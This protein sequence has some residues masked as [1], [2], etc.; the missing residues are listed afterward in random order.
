MF[1]G[2]NESFKYSQRSYSQCGEDSIVLYVF[3]LRGIQNPTYLDIGAN[4]PFYINNTAS[5]YEKG[6]RGINVEANTDLVKL[7][8]K[9]R[10]KDTNLN[11]GIGPEEG[12]MDFFIF[13]DNTLST[14]SSLEAELQKLA[15]GV[16]VEII[17]VKIVTLNHIVENYSKGL[18]PDLL[19]IDVEGVDFEIMQS[20]DFSKSKP[21]II[22]AETA[23][24]S[25]IGAGEKR[26]DY[27]QF[28]E[29]LGYYL[30]ADTNLNS[31][32]LERDFWFNYKK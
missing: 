20:A 16:L 8:E 2:E 30:Y 31:I 3:S 27:I 23:E 15:G 28:I 11:V 24:Y 5:F 7:F 26:K 13:R 14:F 1:F 18:F 12:V 21:R 25:P 32:F 17:K 29:S 9:H 22:C 10:P 6:S 19:T 4:H